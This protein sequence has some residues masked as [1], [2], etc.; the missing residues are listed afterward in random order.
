MD[1]AAEVSDR[2][3]RRVQRTR[4]GLL[5]A[6]NHLVLTRGYDAITAAKIAEQ[7]NIGRSTFYEHF[8]GKK[9]ILAQSLG[10]VLRPLAESLSAIHG[11]TSLTS[12][13]QHFWDN[14]RVGRSL[15][16]G[17]ARLV[18]TRQLAAMIEQNLSAAGEFALPPA[19]LAASLANAQ[20][21]L[22]EEWISGRHEACPAEIAAAIHSVSRAA[23]R[24]LTRSDPFPME[25]PPPDSSHR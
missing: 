11:S 13:V 19:I 4:A 12:A 15:L 16:A 20:L 9:D 5:S 22:L 18:V 23:V 10:P 21:G 7:A 24:S 3:D 8:Q 14:R 6:F 17:R 2:R 25:D 1:F